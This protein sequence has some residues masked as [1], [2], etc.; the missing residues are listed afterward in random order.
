[1]DERL[2]VTD[3]V[4]KDLNLAMVF[5]Q[6]QWK[7]VSG[8]EWKE[9]F[10]I[11]FPPHNAPLQVQPQ[12]YPTMKYWEEWWSMKQRLPAATIDMVQNSF[13]KLFKELLWVPKPHKDRLWKYV[14]NHDFR[15]FLANYSDQAPHIIVS[16]ASHTPR[17]EPER[18]SGGA[19]EVEEEEVS[20]EEHGGEA[21]VDQ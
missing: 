17:W 16:P 15:T 13:W 18:V 14:V 1:M 11:F 5:H 10:N 9:A 8:Q 7:K 20:E 19:D 4:Y 3:N 21:E 2:H 12:D 6:V